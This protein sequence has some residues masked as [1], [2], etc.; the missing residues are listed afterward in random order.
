M[1]PESGALGLQGRASTV[2]VY[3]LGTP[4][5]GYPSEAD[6]GVY[7][8]SKDVLGLGT[9]G[10]GD[11]HLTMG[12]SVLTGQRSSQVVPVFILCVKTPQML[13]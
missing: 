3:T 9:N 2:S 5:L 10:G 13:N 8:W 11:S 1:L 6:M 7:G 4:L 12:F